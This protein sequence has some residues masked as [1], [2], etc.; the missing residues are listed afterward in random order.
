MLDPQGLVLRSRFLQAIRGFFSGRGYI[1]VDTPIRLPALIPEAEIGP[2][3]SGEWWLHTS[4]ELCMK[5]LLARGAGPIF[6]ICH[7]FRDGEQGR[8]HRPEFTLLEWYR[9]GSDYQDLMDECEDL[10]VHL[11]RSCRDF[12]ALVSGQ[13][14]R[15]GSRLI[16]LTPP[17]DRI[18][19][20]KAFCRH[21]G[22]TA[23]Q[24][25]A[26]GCFDELL[27]TR[28]EANLGWDRPVFLYDYPASL[29]SLARV[30]ADNPALA[31]RFE[32]YLAGIELANGF[33][34]L[35]DPDEQRRRFLRE[36]ELARGKGRIVPLPEKFLADLARMEPAAGIALGVD[37]LLLLFLGEDELGRVMPLAP[38]EC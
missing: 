36:Q 31:E 8:L 13:A 10:F 9:P 37:R 33:S 3:A 26:D 15:R 18:T 35:A 21:T 16:A 29:A 11:A 32:I 28:I 5:R 38:E 22:V 27:V 1:E 2:V 4:P 7:C 34:E 30:R 14:L 23:E 12:P 6:Q 19:V 24:A 20:D 17:W 25:L